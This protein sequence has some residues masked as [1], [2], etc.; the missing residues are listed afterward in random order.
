MF[1]TIS[2]T[3]AHR[4][5]LTINIQLSN[6]TKNEVELQLPS[7]RPGRYELGN[8]A[9]NIRDFQV[10]DE[11]NNPLPFKKKSKDLWVVSNIKGQSVSVT[12]LYY[13]N[14]VNAGSCFVDDHLFYVNPIQCCMYQMGKENDA[15][16]LKL[17]YP[18]QYNISLPEYLKKN[19]NYL[20]QNFDQLVET[21]FLASEGLKKISYSIDGFDAV[22]NIWFEGVQDIPTE[23]I[24]KDFKAFTKKQLE[25]F[26][27]LPVK[28]YDFIFLI[29]PFKSYHGVE[30]TASTIITLGPDKDLFEPEMY[31]EFLHISSHELYHTWNIKA[32]RP[33]VMKPYN[34]SQENYSKL[35]FWYEGLT[36]L[37]G[38]LIL[39]ESKVFSDEE[40]NN[41]LNKYLK[42][43]YFNH[44][45]NH[46]SV[47][48]SSFDTWLDGYQIGIPNRKVSI[49]QDG[50]LCMLMIHAAILEHTA[51]N[52]SL[53]T[54]MKD[55]Y[56][57]LDVLQNGFSEQFL[58]E[59][60]INAGGEKVSEI[61]KN[62]VYGTEDYTL[63][64]LEACDY[65]GWTFILD[66]NED[67]ITGILGVQTVKQKEGL[68]IVKAIEGGLADENKM[69][70]GDV[71]TKINGKSS[72]ENFDNCSS[73][74]TVE[75]KSKYK[76]ETVE[77][78]FDLEYIS[79]YKIYKI[80]CIAD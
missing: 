44:G 21:P 58:L 65:F 7:W 38:D 25:Y 52:Q 69:A 19:N 28:E 77:I 51:G 47:A 6:L 60:L 18:K 35:G 10:V 75:F 1:Y 57:N 68:K 46:L 80:N 34:L 9:K 59:T 56:S 36:T 62:Y 66:D 48:D 78:T 50:A 41:C 79:G 72:Q 29:T 17:E 43:H 27:S 22:F 55:L 4:H 39:W 37:M 53:H 73:P 74:L 33:D 45:H 26:G 23:K 32:I 49:Y 15:L 61:I 67:V 70:V 40:W 31:R 20:F 2:Y 3:N 11:E 42:V 24:L 16:E 12:Y 76:T 5:F 54:V 64:I 13:A 63:G 30:H 71:I 8:F 14:E